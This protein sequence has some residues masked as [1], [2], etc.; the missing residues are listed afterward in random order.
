MNRDRITLVVSDSFNISKTDPVLQDL[1]L[2]KELSNTQEVRLNKT[3]AG[4]S[5]LFSC[6]TFTKINTSML[7]NHLTKMF[8]QY[9]SQHFVQF[10]IICMHIKSEE[11]M[12]AIIGLHEYCLEMDLPNVNYIESKSIEALFS[13][14]YEEEDDEEYDIPFDSFYKKDK[15]SKT[16]SRLINDAKKSIKRHN[17]IISSSRNARK[18]DEKVIKEFLKEFLAGKADWIK[19]YRNEMLHRWMD[20]FAITEKTARKLKRST[21]AKANKNKAVHMTKRLLHM[22]DPFYDINR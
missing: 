22:H 15:P 8:T 11:C 10:E 16:R 21:N 18:R 4:Y 6:D 20:A 19:K 17:I 3:S 5:I 1:V 13:D 7:G 14:D 9:F 2:G 12:E